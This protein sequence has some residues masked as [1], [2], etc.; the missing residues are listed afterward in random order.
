MEEKEII[1]YFKT[2][3]EVT[4]NQI[5]NGELYM[6]EDLEKEHIKYIKGLLN[7]YNKKMEEK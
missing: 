2:Y 1:N 7:L 4:E 3:I 6:L 5:K